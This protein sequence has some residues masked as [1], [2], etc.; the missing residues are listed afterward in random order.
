MSKSST[1]YVTCTL[2]GKTYTW[3]FTGITE[4]E[5]N[6]SVRKNTGS[7]G[8]TTGTPLQQLLSKTL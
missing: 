1:A 2:G 3:H 4:I 5:H 8:K 6:S 7:T